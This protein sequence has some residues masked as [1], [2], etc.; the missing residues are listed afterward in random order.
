VEVFG[1]SAIVCKAPRGTLPA[2]PIDLRVELPTVGGIA[3]DAYVL[4]DAYDYFNDTVA[5]DDLMVLAAIP[6]SGPQSGA[7]IVTIAG[8]GFVTGAKVYFG[9]VAATQVNVLAPEA[10]TCV[11]PRGVSVG[12]VDIRV[13]LPGASGDADTLYRGYTY[14]D[15]T[16]PV[17]P[18]LV[19]KTI[20]NSGPV[21][22][23]NVVAIEG[24]GFVDGANYV[25]DACTPREPAE[26]AQV[27]GDSR[28]AE[29]E[30]QKLGGW[31]CG[32]YRRLERAV[33]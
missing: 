21:T 20:P 26:V 16:E 5:P 17:E 22:G 7:N 14:V 23:G 25:R 24:S 8:Q 2:G 31:S 3:G 27:V 12:A 32:A 30:H 13:E 1:T 33:E 10:L 11:A 9:G 15:D 28:V 6:V 29:R 19:L 4:E 18:F